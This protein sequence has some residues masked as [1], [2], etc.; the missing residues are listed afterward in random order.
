MFGALPKKE[1][2][3]YIPKLVLGCS[4]C[5][6]RYGLS[7]IGAVPAKDKIFAI[8]FNKTGTSSLHELFVHFGYHSNH[9]E[10]WRKTDSTKFHLLFDAFCDGIPDDFTALDSA[11]VGSKFILQVRDLDTWISS[12]IDHIQRRPVD[13]S[14]TISEDWTAANESISSWVLKRNEYHLEVMQYF[15]D[16]PQDLLIVN[17]IRDPMATSKI[18]KF[19]GSKTIPSKPHANKNRKN[20]GK[21][22]HADIISKCLRELG[23]PEEEWSSDLLCMSLVNGEQQSTPVFYDTQ[24][25]L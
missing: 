23:I 18:A 14:N 11:F 5:V 6:I 19:L 13:R 7:H 3:L 22:K 17:Y 24:D 16:R 21:L 8:G 9:G 10:Y 1:K 2:I 12:R 15:R 25:M 20:S 4:G